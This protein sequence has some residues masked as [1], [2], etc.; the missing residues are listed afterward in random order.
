[1]ADG[2]VEYVIRLTDKTKTGTA[3]AVAGSRELENQTQATAEALDDLG[4]EAKRAGD[5]VDDMGDEA[6]KAG[7]KIDDLGDDTKTT[8]RSVD[9]LITG[10]KGLVGI[11]AVDQLIGVLTGAA[12]AVFDF[13]Q[14]V[15]DLRNQITDTATRSGIAAETLQGIRFAAE[16]AGVGFEELMTDLDN[17]GRMM[18]D[19]ST[20]TGAQ[21][22]AFAALQVK[23]DDAN[24]SLRDVDSVFRETLA[25]LAAMPPSAE[26][27]AL[28][29][30]L[31]SAE[32]GALALD[33]FGGA[34]GRLIQSLGGGELEDFIALA[35]DFG[36]NVGPDAAKAASDW[37]RASA[38]L[39][40]VVDGLKAE[41][42][43]AAGGADALFA[44]G[45]AAIYL[46]EVAGGYISGFVDGVVTGLGRIIAPLEAVGR[47]IGDVILAFQAIARGDFDAGLERLSS[48]MSNLGEAIRS[49]PAAAASLLTGGL[50]EGVVTG[51]ERAST[52]ADT[53]AARVARLQEAR[54]R[55]TSTT[56]TGAGGGNGGRGPEIDTEEVEAAATAA[57]E[58]SS[59]VFLSGFEEDRRRLSD[60]LAEGA[61][62]LAEQQA[63]A[64]AE[65]EATR[66][67]RL[68]GVQTGIGVAGQVLGG[69]LGGGLSSIAGAT[70]RAG[71]GV[72]GAALSGL[73]AI[74]EQGA[75]GIRE[76]LEGVKDALIA[77]LE[78]LPQLIG[79]VLPQFAISLVSELIPAL[80]RA[81]PQILRSILVDLPI[82]IA[83]ALRELIGLDR[84]VGRVEERVRGSEFLQNVS[85]VVAVATG[86]RREEGLEELRD[87]GDVGEVFGN[88]SARTA[89]DGQ[90]S[91]ARAADRLAT[92][93]TRPRR[94]RQP[95]AASNP[96]DQLA[97]AY[98]SEYG[99]YGR[100]R[101][102]TIGVRP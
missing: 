21:A 90:A 81:A 71:L 4:D 48:S 64:A 75:E 97:R 82:A 51:A 54:A 98:D 63:K 91:N 94:G 12:E 7:R 1:M 28:A 9:G 101:A 20:G 92:F 58:A 46:F 16:G 37:Q 41:L 69:D 47:A 52:G 29:L 102:T 27:G 68:E 70:G 85:A 8:T 31:F 67:R 87:R 24:G 44:L 86:M 55:I 84:A 5:A 62:N 34:G 76:T 96:F 61:R 45:E 36:V 32:R 11:L 50:V 80:I 22:D 89:S 99:T 40:T 23:V 25:A 66:L 6:R 59:R 95:V 43:D 2:T 15:A 77:A 65:A 60:V 73:Q 18:R 33:L 56:A 13:G 10:L 53:A 57:A 78:A 42:F 35:R 49:G 14:E 30:D 79:D 83:N 19:A 3:S 39:S 26:R 100:A 74:G 17:F 88:R 93:S 38:E 72:A